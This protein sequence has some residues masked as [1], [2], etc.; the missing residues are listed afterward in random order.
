MPINSRNYSD[1]DFNFI[2]HPITKDIPIKYNED[3]INAS[4]KNLI[5]TINYE[6]PF[7]SEVG[8][9][10]VAI[11]FENNGPMTELK[12]RR[13]IED[14]INNFEPRIELNNLDIVYNAPR[15]NYAITIFYRILNT[16]APIEFNFILERTR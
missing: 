7:H 10:A 3:A 14:V 13:S 8:S 5:L 16:N 15:N 6:R 4:L 1:I 9:Q 12:L 11:L 2:P